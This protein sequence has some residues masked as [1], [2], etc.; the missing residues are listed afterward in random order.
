MVYKSDYWRDTIRGMLLEK[1]NQYIGTGDAVSVVA[2]SLGSVVAF[3]TI[4]YNSLNNEQWKAANFK[5][6]NLFTMGSPIA[7]FC[8]DLDRYNGT[9]L[10]KYLP[11]NDPDLQPVHPEGVWYNFLDPQDLIGYPLEKLFAEEFKVDDVIVQTGSNPRKAH[12]GYWD[13]DEVAQIIA[14]RLKVDYARINDLA[15]VE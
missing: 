14:E 11:R 5:P 2:H 1:L 4:H 10:P 6:T 3:E 12:D 13:N 8:L 7:L 15:P 9:N